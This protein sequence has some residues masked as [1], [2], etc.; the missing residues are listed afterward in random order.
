MWV[1]DPRQ[2]MPQWVE[3][4]FDKPV[5]FNTVYLTF[6]TDMNNPPMTYANKPRVPQ[7]VRDYELI[8]DGRQTLAVGR[9]NFQ[10]RRVHRFPALE[11]TT[12][13]LN[14]AATNGD[15]SARVHEIRVYHE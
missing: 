8:A 2:A 7:C 1:S 14:I 4:R 10:R 5:K 12:L 3:L 13:R 6:D 11:A 9:E 15:P